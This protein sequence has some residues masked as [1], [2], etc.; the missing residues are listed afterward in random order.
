MSNISALLCAKSCKN[1]I[2]NNSYPFLSTL[3]FTPATSLFSLPTPIPNQA[4]QPEDYYLRNMLLNGMEM[5]LKNIAKYC[6]KTD[7][8]V[9]A[10]EGYADMTVEKGKMEYSFA[11]F[12]YNPHICGIEPQSTIE[13]MDQ[14][15]EQLNFLNPDAVYL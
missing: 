7:F 1:H 9:D 8:T 13:G 6:A 2:D 14:T 12:Y 15:N 5:I 10:A 4:Y 3:P 11:F